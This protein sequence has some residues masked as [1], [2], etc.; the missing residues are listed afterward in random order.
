MDTKRCST[1]EQEL[2]IEHFYV[3]KDGQ[4]GYHSECKGCKKLRSQKRYLGDVKKHARLVKARYDVHGRFAKYGITLEIYDAMLASQDGKCALCKKDKPGGKGKWHIAHLGGTN[5]SVRKQ[6]AA[7]SVRGLLC[8]NCNV[9][10]GHYEKLLQRVGK[11]AVL[12][13]LKE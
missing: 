12:H 13:Y 4:T 7:D 2:G 10:L 8:H 1:C 5:Q 11:D 3:R 9:S 6:C